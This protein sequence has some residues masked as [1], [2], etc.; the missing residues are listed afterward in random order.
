MKVCPHV[1]GDLFASH[2][3]VPE[4]VSSDRQTAIA[5]LQ[6]PLMEAMIDPAVDKRSK[7][8]GRQ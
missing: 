1:Q 3:G 2:G 6:A 4:L 7:A 5:L 8:G